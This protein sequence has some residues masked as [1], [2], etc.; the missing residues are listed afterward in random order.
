[1]IGDTDRDRIG[2]VLVHGLELGAWVWD[3]VVPLLERPTVAVDLPG[4]GSRPAARRS[5]SLED[6][7]RAIVAD[8]GRCRAD[9]LIVVFH[10]FSGVLAPPVVSELG[11]RAAAVVFVGA[12]VPVEGRRWVDLQPAAQRILLR[13]LYRLWPD[14]LLSPARQNRTTLANDL[15]PEVTTAFLERR[16]P[17]APRL[18]LDKVTPAV[19]PEGIPRHYV[20]LTEDRT[21]TDGRRD[22]MIRRLTPVTT[23]DL[24][25]GHLPMLG[26]AAELA[27]IL[28]DVASATA[29]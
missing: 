1:M 24:A 3:D 13:V 23:H 8:A 29:T 21:I 4:R 10:S 22:E 18:L 9:R 26:K 25:S 17:E 6:G 14:G 16:V 7:V 12:T 20:R 19:M 2:F 27:T 15:D 5:V 11:D 28:D